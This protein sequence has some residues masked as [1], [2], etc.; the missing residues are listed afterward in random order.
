MCMAYS[1][2]KV[3]SSRKERKSMIR[4][5][6]SLSI[7]SLR[8]SEDDLSGGTLKP[9]QAVPKIASRTTYK[10]SRRS[11]SIDSIPD[12]PSYTS[13]SQDDQARQIMEAVVI[14][15]NASVPD[16]IYRPFCDEVEETHDLQ[17]PGE[18]HRKEKDRGIPVRFLDHF[19]CYDE[20]GTYV[21]FA[22]VAAYLVSGTTTRIRASGL[23]SR[24]L[25][26]WEDGDSDLSETEVQLLVSLQPLEDFWTNYEA[27][28]PRGIWTVQSVGIATAHAWYILQQPAPLYATFYQPFWLSHRLTWLVAKAIRKD[29][30]ITYNFFCQQLE[31]AK[32]DEADLIMGR[33][34]IR[35]DLTGDLPILYIK[36]HL[37]VKG[38]V[39]D[40][41]EL[42][43]SPLL[44]TILHRAHTI[45]KTVQ[46]FFHLDEYASI[47]DQEIR[48]KKKKNY[49]S[50]SVT[51]TTPRIHELTTGLFLKTLLKAGVT[52]DI[53]DRRNDLIQP[54][55]PPDK[56]H[57]DPPTHI[58]WENPVSGVRGYFTG[59]SLDGEPYTVGDVVMV[60]FLI[61][62]WLRF[63]DL[64]QVNPGEDELTHRAVSAREAH[65]QSRKNNLANEVWFGKIIYMFDK[66]MSSESHNSQR[67]PTFH[68]Q[69]YEHGSRTILQETAHPYGLFAL[70]E[71]ADIPVGSIFGS[72]SVQH[73]KPGDEEP[74][75][76]HCSFLW[77]AQKA[78]FL[79]Q[80]VLR[81]T[82]AVM[83]FPHC[84][85]CSF[86]K[87]RDQEETHET[88]LH[89]DTYAEV[90]GVKY[91]KNDFVYIA[92]NESF[93]Y[94]IGQIRCFTVD[95]NFTLDKSKVELTLLGRFDDVARALNGSEV[96][97]DETRLFMTEQMGTFPL[98]FI[99]GKCFVRPKGLVISQDLPNHFYVDLWAPKL[100]IRSLE[101]LLPLEGQVI[102]TC[103]PCLQSERLDQER[104]HSYK[105]CN[106]PLK[107]MELFAG[108]FDCAGGLSTGL[109]QSGFMKTKWAV[110]IVPGPA[111]TFQ[112][113]H[114]DAVVFNQDTNVCLQ[115]AIDARDGKPCIPLKSIGAGKQLPRMPQRGDVDLITGGFPCQSFSGMNHQ[116]HVNSHDDIRTTLVAN[117]LS[118]VEF[119][120]PRYVLMENVK[121]LLQHHSRLA[122]LDNDDEENESDDD[123]QKVI[124]MSIVKFVLRALLRLGYQTQFTV[125]QGSYD[126]KVMP[127]LILSSCHTAAD[128]GSP[129]RRERVIF[130]AARLSEILPEFPLPTHVYPGYKSR[131]LSLPTHDKLSPVQRSERNC[132]PFRALVV[133]D[134]ISDLPK[135]D[136]KNPHIICPEG[137]AE[138]EE[139]SR[140]R[141]RY[142]E[143]TAVS[144]PARTLAGF[145]EPVPYATSPKTKYQRIL[146]GDNEVVTLHCSRTFRP[147]TVERVWHVCSAHVN[148]PHDLPRELWLPACTKLSTDE[149]KLQQKWQAL[150]SRLK[151]KEPFNTALTSCRP[152][153]KG[154]KVLHPTQKRIITAR[155]CARSQ[156][157]PDSYEFVQTDEDGGPAAWAKLLD[158]IHTQIGNAVPV[159]LACA[160]GK[161]LGK[162][163]V[164]RWLQENLDEGESDK[165]DALV[166]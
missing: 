86:I 21:P 81:R 56:L 33:D 67:E 35:K 22:S 32:D 161:S 83:G 131:V 54:H 145:L 19:T 162:A 43:S 14:T 107:T 151:W 159:P 135:F 3:G 139:T 111:A 157:F 44:Q 116:R 79:D 121:G 46:E 87:K 37:S 5:E 11:L 120:E 117:M 17:V 99:E 90:R 115:N 40:Y 24:C 68:V 1:Y 154:S 129:Q 66:P 103:K 38:S 138:A 114:P 118:Y 52:L 13:H 77:D 141:K 71:C 55:Q 127:L 28:Q 91:H 23:V 2:P 132:A 48:E 156:G 133:A 124:K 101:D 163:L 165:E 95:R 82:G 152:F 153:M 119:Y 61:P 49:S 36:D 94:L 106:A 160:L 16:P 6:R 164:T 31:C 57:P 109:E 92:A 166:R 143:R 146:R 74:Q 47:S 136:W 42:L 53:Q 104:V 29:P 137:E 60:C 10:H 128:Y 15:P 158:D 41:K 59:V 73:L 18:G 134:A 130:W 51:I 84:P 85:C 50:K 9:P 63:N 148:G 122:V 64:L 89:S 27:H 125:L 142:K 20:N 112:A 102:K 144:T 105:S 12:T 93:P 126:N 98:P 110:E 30:T 26:D 69:W 25:E 88:L 147:T 72:C 34:L 62:N 58:E 4:G 96:Q 7:D 39:K 80:S 8:D 155:E 45:G 100:D 70:A 76:Y 140:R 75:D 149:A 97:Q 65:S 108:R 123:E 113:N 150:F 78:C